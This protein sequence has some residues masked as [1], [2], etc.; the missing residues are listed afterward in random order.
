V[1]RRTASTGID[2]M[3]A[4]IYSWS[5]H[6]SKAAKGGA[7]GVTAR[8]RSRSEQGSIDFLPDE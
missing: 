5:S 6:P 7:A 4:G 2:V 3:G 1:R 8:L